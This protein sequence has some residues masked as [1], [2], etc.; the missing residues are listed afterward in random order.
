MVHS[1]CCRKKFPVLPQQP[2]SLTSSTELSQ[3]P[4]AS[5]GNHLFLLIRRSS[6]WKSK[7][8]K[9][10]EII[11]YNKRSSISTDEK[12]ISMH[13]LFETGINIK[14]CEQASKRNFNLP[15]GAVTDE[16]NSFEVVFAGGSLLVHQKPLVK[17]LLSQH[18][19]LQKQ[20]KYI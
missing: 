13:R 15:V 6:D 1:L 8:S 10:R 17:L 20:K 16:F 4:I 11:F 3:T 7:F 5:M 2:W 18:S 9:P 12:K 14:Y 19:P